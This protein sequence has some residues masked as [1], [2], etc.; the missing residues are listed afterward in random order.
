VKAGK[1]PRPPTLIELDASP[2]Q[3][4]HLH[5]GAG[6]EASCPVVASQRTRVFHEATCGN[7]QRIKAENRRCYPSK[8]AAMAAGKR[9]A[10]CC[11]P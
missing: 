6:G 11:R 9:T 10:G 3:P 4:T 5:A 1:Q 2:L 8:E 7:A